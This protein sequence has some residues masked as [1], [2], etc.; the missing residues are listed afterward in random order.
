MATAP[1]G[2]VGT[3][4]GIE[5]AHSLSGPLRG[6]AEYILRNN[7]QAGM[8]RSLFSLVKM[9]HLP[10]GRS[11]IA[12]IRDALAGSSNRGRLEGLYVTQH[13]VGTSV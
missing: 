12:R 1:D 5:K 4:T 8:P 9:N 11:D 10:R 3:L 13:V 2:E 6:G 7:V